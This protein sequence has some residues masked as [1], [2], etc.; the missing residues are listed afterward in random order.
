MVMRLNPNK[1]R[2]DGLTRL[3]S[4]VSDMTEKVNPI[5]ISIIH[6]ESIL[7]LPGNCIAE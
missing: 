4:V 2:I 3:T 5:H 6:H 1:K 7:K